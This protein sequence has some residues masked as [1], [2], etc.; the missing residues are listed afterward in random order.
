MVY[1]LIILWYISSSPPFRVLLHSVFTLLAGSNWA[2]LGGREQPHAEQQSPRR[3]GTL[4]LT[5]YQ[6]QRHSLSRDELASKRLSHCCTAVAVLWTYNHPIKSE[7]TQAGVCREV[8]V[9]T[10]LSAVCRGENPLLWTRPVLPAPLQLP[11]LAGRNTAESDWGWWEYPVGYQD[12][13]RDSRKGTNWPVFSL[14]SMSKP[15]VL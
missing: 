5:G 15:P 13:A 4:Q 6:T 7:K 10:T 8:G 9:A 3:P 2:P 12:N 11:S 14:S 1:F